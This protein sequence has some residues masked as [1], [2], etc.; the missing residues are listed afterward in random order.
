MAVLSQPTIEELIQNVRNML[1]QPDPNNSTWTDEE[2][3]E[4]LN[5][6]VRRYFAEVILYNE[7]QFDDVADLDIVAG[8]ETVDLPADC[9]SVKAVYKKVNGGYTLLHYRNGAESYSTNGGTT[10]DSFLPYY[11]FRKNS[12]VLRDVPQFSETG[13]LRVEYVAFPE[14]MVT[15]GDSL[16]ESVSPIFKDLIQMYAI[17]QAKVKESLTNNTRTYDAALEMLNDLFSAFQ[18]AIVK[19]AATPAAIKPFNPESSTGA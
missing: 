8:Q 18:N 7:G 9:Y 16:T 2:I 15:G 5:Q 14:T 11:R 3:S 19:R 1:S 17:Y 13:G 6:G 10:S 4:Y 12:L